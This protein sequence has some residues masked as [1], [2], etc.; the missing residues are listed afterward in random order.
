MV[1]KIVELFNG[2]LLSASSDKTV[3]IWDRHSGEIIN[4]LEGFEDNILDI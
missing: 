2:N 1:S 3:N 4:T